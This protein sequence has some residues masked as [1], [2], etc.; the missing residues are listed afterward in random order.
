MQNSQGRGEKG[1]QRMPAITLCDRILV[2]TASDYPQRVQ[3]SRGTKEKTPRQ[4]QVCF[5]A[6]DTFGKKNQSLSLSLSV[7]GPVHS[8]K[9]VLEKS[10]LFT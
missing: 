3:Y 7:S 8:L 2:H 10:H 4:A 5:P 1:W 6:R 9:C